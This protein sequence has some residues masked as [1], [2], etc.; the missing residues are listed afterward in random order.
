MKVKGLHAKR[1]IAPKSPPEGS[2][3]VWTLDDFGYYC[4]RDG[5]VVSETPIEQTG[6]YICRDGLPQ[7]FST[8]NCEALRN[9]SSASMN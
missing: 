1:S 4:D 2:V 8:T 7:F 9:S 5:I 3:R 6:L